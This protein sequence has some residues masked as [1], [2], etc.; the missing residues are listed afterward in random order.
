[1]HDAPI[2]RF[3]S[4]FSSIS[5]AFN[6][7][8]NLAGR[9]SRGAFWWFFAFWAAGT[10][11][12][13][14]LSD[15]VNILFW[16]GSAIPLFA[17]FVRRLHDVGVSALNFFLGAGVWVLVWYWGMVAMIDQVSS[18]FFS[19]VVIFVIGVPSCVGL[20]LCLA[21]GTRG[22]NKFGRDVEA[23]RF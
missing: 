5:L 15:H 14:F 4:P 10:C 18:A 2:H 19:N 12:L 20:L 17:V 13:I 9:S 23:G 8:F 7:A 22:T 3:V 6:N 21:A 1:M 16:V 11:I